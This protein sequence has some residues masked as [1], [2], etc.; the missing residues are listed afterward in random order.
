MKLKSFAIF[1]E[2]IG[3]YN[4]P[5]FERAVG[6]AVRTFGDAVNDE[7]S[8]LNKHPEDFALYEIGAYDEE[9]GAFENLPKPHQLVRATECHK[10]YNQAKA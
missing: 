10:G 3:A 9:S 6:L 7:K 5:F 4:P 8:G 1:D 2:K